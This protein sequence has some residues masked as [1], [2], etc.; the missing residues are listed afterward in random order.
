MMMNDLR[1][2]PTPP[3]DGGSTPKIVAALVVALGF[4][5]MGLYTYEAGTWSSAPKYA[6]ASK[7]VPPSESVASA[8]PSEAPLPS[9]TDLPP[10]PVKAAD[11]PPAPVKNVAAQTSPPVRVARAQAPAIITSPPAPAPQTAANVS[12]PAAVEVAT[13]AAS[14]PEQP[15]SPAAGAAPPASAPTQ[16][17]P[18]QDASA[19]SA[20]QP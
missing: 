19:P 16:E 6:V 15:T 13:P 7:P 9:T 18:T 3:V 4:G 14:I 17:A 1:E 10:A 20:P 12:A 2:T 8:A 11:L 5:A